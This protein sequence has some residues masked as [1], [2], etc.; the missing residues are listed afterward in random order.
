VIEFKPA[1]RKYKISN[2][3]ID[4]ARYSILQR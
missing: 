4:S 1:H 3:I 2:L